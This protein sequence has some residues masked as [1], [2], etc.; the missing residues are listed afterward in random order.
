MGLKLNNHAAYELGK[1]GERLSSK[2]LIKKGYTIL[3]LNFKCK[4]GEIDIIARKNDKIYFFE[5]KTRSSLFYGDP[6]DFIGESQLSH[7]TK[8]IGYFIKINSLEGLEIQIDVIEML[9]KDG[10][11]NIR[12]TENALIL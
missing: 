3:D 5:V 8:A 1:K 10:K 11:W 6:I 2:Y 7:L 4:L 9:V 12:H